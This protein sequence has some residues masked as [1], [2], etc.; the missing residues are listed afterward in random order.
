[1]VTNAGQCHYAAVDRRNG[2]S[3]TFK[4]TMRRTPLTSRNM[5]RFAASRGA[6]LVL[7]GLLVLGS[8]LTATAQSVNAESPNGLEGTWRVRLTVSDCQTGQVLRTFPTLF[9]FAKGGTVTFTTAGQLPSLATPGLGTWHHMDDH[10]YSAVSEVFIFSSAGAWIQTHRLTRIIEVSTDGDQFTDTVA[11]QIFD[12]NGNQIV[13]GCGT[14]VGS[15][16]K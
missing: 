2:V 15:R 8:G 5:K 11:L 12:T 16:M 1:M 6:A 13:T 7:A 4:T 14:S 3:A 9:A 10:T